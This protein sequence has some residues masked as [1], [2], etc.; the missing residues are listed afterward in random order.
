MLIGIL[1]WSIYFTIEVKRIEKEFGYKYLQDLKY[2]IGGGAV[3]PLAAYY[4]VYLNIYLYYAQAVI[5]I[6][7][8][9]F[10]KWYRKSY[11]NLG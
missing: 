4:N 1:F 8:V 3:T 7:I 9:L 6:F 5:N 10:I 11:E 2:S